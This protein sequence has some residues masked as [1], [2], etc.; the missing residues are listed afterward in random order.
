MKIAISSEGIPFRQKLI[1][2]LEDVL[3]L[4]LRHRNRQHSVLINPAK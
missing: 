2:I 4:L 1:P 3:I